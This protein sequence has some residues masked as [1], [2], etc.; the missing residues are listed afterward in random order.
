MVGRSTNREC[1]VGL[2]ISHWGDNLNVQDDI[3]LVNS[4]PTYVQTSLCT[5]LRTQLTSPCVTLC[6][7]KGQFSRIAHLQ[8][9]H[10]RKMPPTTLSDLTLKLPAGA[11]DP[12][13]YD[14]IGNVS[15]SNFRSP[16]TSASTLSAAS[17]ARGLH[18]KEEGATLELKP[19]YPVLGGWN[20]TFTV[21][22]DQPLS[23]SLKVADGDRYVL[24]VP[25]VSAGLRDLVWEDVEFVV[26]LP[27]GATYV[28]CN[29]ARVGPS[30]T[31]QIHTGQQGR[32]G[33]RAVPSRDSGRG[34]HSYRLPR[35]AWTAGR[36]NRQEAMCRAVRHVW[37]GLRSLFPLRLS[38]CTL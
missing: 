28:S 24:G 31:T 20:Y 5:T 3:E 33:C 34:V 2:Q 8:G 37:S 36:S 15:T 21:G 25:F 14:I 27:E 11:R 13:F 22:W 16:K 30:L 38:A 10:Y 4:G 32:R 19:R 29:L 35:H 23:D 9:R 26:I 12:Y 6:S 7:L 1:L 18:K 17:K